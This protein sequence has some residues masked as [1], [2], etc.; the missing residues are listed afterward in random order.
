MEHRTHV[1]ESSMGARARLCLANHHAASV[2]CENFHKLGSDG[3]R[4][5]PGRAASLVAKALLSRAAGITFTGIRKKFSQGRQ[6]DVH[7]FF[8]DVC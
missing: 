2:L 8:I 3:K 6:T 4:R 5:V 1:Q 7:L